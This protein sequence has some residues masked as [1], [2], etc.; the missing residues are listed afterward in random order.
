MVLSKVGRND[1]CP[2]GSG[3][4]HKQCCGRTGK[5]AAAE[6]PV[7][8]RDRRGQQLQL[9]VDRYRGPSEVLPAG[10]LHEQ[11]QLVAE[12]EWVDGEALVTSA[13]ISAADR[14]RYRLEKAGCQHQERAI[15]QPT[16]DAAPALGMRDFKVSFFERWLDEP[17]EP[18]SGLTPRQAAAGP[19]RRALLELVRSLEAREARLPSAERYDFSGVRKVLG[20]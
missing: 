18:L 3:R 4:K 20:L 1:P 12:I 7:P 8:L 11:D 16:L 9:V 6:T 15:S 2:C 19:Q 14:L 17:L 13:S 5:V 10:A